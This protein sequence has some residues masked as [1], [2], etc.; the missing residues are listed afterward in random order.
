MELDFGLDYFMSGALPTP[1]PQD[2]DI[3]HLNPLELNIDFQLGCGNKK[4]SSMDHV[5]RPMNAFM[6][7][8]QIE[9][10]KMA[11]IYPDMHNAEIS[12]RLGK[13]WKLLSDADRRPFV[14]RSEKLREEHMRRY[15]DYKYRPKKKA[16]E[17]AAKELAAKELKNFSKVC[18]YN[19]VT[20][21]NGRN[22]DWDKSKYTNNVACC[23]NNKA[24][25]NKTFVTISRQVG[26]IG[27]LSNI[28]V[29]PQKCIDIPPSTLS[30]PSVVPDCCGTPPDEYNSESFYNYD[31]F[32]GKNNSNSLYHEDMDL[33]IN[34]ARFTDGLPDLYTTPEVSEM[35]TGQWL[36]N[37]LGF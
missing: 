18:E 16:K 21:T 17:L 3:K 30:P 10:K 20:L 2:G 28:T 34:F 31:S 6:V 24:P 26:Q 29:S 25:P 7:W 27:S 22:D 4:K 23:E 1:E 14:I 5:K 11:D 12:R 13:R 36:E 9:R 37:D 33:L 15:P 19:I 35:L 32:S 8:S